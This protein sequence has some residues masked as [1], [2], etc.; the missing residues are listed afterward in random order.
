MRSSTGSAAATDAES[1]DSYK[2]AFV[3][4]TTA[5][6]SGNVDDSSATATASSNFVHGSV[7]GAVLVVS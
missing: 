4:G 7:R 2:R 1:S 3:L 6:V 5:S